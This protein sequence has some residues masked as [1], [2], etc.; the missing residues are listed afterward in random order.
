MLS[1]E[2][3]HSEKLSAMCLQYLHPKIIIYNVANVFSLIKLDINSH[4]MRQFVIRCFL[5]ADTIN[6][7]HSMNR[8]ASF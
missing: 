6:T 3:M 1:V 8:L 7:G 5:S 2:H 4:Q